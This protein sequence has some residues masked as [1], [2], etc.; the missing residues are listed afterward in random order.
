MNGGARDQM[1]SGEPGE[2]GGLWNRQ[3]RDVSSRRLAC[4]PIA[5]KSKGVMK[6]AYI[7]GGDAT[8]EAVTVGPDWCVRSCPAQQSSATR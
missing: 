5:R 4:A 7:G 8:S 2:I 6:K 3:V 1:R